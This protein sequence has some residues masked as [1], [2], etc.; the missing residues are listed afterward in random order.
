MGSG[1][2]RADPRGAMRDDRI[3]EADDVNA[4]LEHAGGELL[5]FGRVA[6]HDRHDR[7]CAWFDR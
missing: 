1:N 4:F 7:M 3:E 2:L 6:N 5:R